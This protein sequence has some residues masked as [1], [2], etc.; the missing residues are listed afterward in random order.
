MTPLFPFW[1]GMLSFL[2]PC[3][4]PMI[5]VYLSLITGMTLE[6]LSHLSDNAGL[7]R[8]VL[9]NTGVFILGFGIIFTLAGGTASFLVNSF[10]GSY[11]EGFTRVGGFMV[12]LLGLHLSGILRMS[13]LDRLSLA[14][15]FS[16]ER[17]PVGLFGS[18]LVGIFFAIA[19]SHCIGPFLYST[20]I[21]AASTGSVSQGL[22][23]MAA[24]SSGLAI[25]YLLTAIALTPVLSSLKR[26]RRY[27]RF[28]SVLSGGFLVFF[29]L[30]MVLNR[31]TLLTDLFSRLLPYRIPGAM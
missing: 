31:F 4:V 24:F 17:K 12:I 1:A 15:R 25:P 13:F 28:I 23:T 8:G 14:D 21:Y 2:S 11:R 26:A 27:M 19:C 9:L 30:L 5:G 6:E 22:S 7:R 18:F 3:I 29:G 10:L 20:L 16:I